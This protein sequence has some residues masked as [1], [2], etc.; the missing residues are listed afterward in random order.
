MLWY[1]FWTLRF[2]RI[3]LLFYNLDDIASFLSFWVL[4][5]PS[6]GYFL[7]YSPWEWEKS[8]ERWCRSKRG[9]LRHCSLS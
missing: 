4:V 7:Y 5:F 3:L 6:C 9:R 1:V 2:V 8:E